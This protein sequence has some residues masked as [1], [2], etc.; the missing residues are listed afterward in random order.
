MASKDSNPL[1]VQRTIWLLKYLRKHS[2][3][4]H[5]VK[6]RDIDAYFHDN[7][8]EAA[9][10]DKKTRRKLIEDL[11]MALNYD[12]REHP[13]P[14]EQCRIYYNSLFDGEESETAR[15]SNITKLYYRQE[16]T[17]K[18]ID[19]LEEGV[20]FLSSLEPAQRARLIA[21]IEE[22][23][24]TKFH[25]KKTGLIQTVYQPFAVDQES[26]YRSLTVLQEAIR[27]KKKVQ[28]IFNGY[29]CLQKLVPTCQERHT[30]SPY[31]IVAYGGRYYLLGASDRYKNLSI[32]R[33]D[34]MS[35][36]ECTEEPILS[37]R[38]TGVMEKWDDKFPYEH[39]N[40]FFDAPVEVTLRVRNEK[41]TAD[42]KT[43]HRPGYTFLYDWFGPTF[44]Y[45]K[46]ETEPP[47]DDIVQVRCSPEAMAHW[48][49]Q[50]SDRVEVLEPKALREKIADMVR[51]L[52]EKYL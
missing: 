25:R 50:Y 8:M 16:F 38:E 44:Q 15:A 28:Y 11:A 12:E 51:S 32:W 14:D 30:L 52:G 42:P 4:N 29:D 9:L 48:A 26:L 23:L 41:S 36:L 24:A 46:T 2:S 7:D 49:L 35:K 22:H 34:L 20:L 18:E 39:L 1:H 47:Y 27:K 43:A 5:P 13:L 21:K 40:M 45:I 33:V 10:M 37:K 31:Y 17:D 6:M 3:P 19:Q